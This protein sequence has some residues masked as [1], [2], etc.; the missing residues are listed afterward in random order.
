VCTRVSTDTCILGHGGIGHNRQRVVLSRTNYYLEYRSIIESGSDNFHVDIP[1]V[2]EAIAWCTSGYLVARFHRHV[3][4]T[5][6]GERLAFPLGKDEDMIAI[7]VIVI[8]SR[9]IGNRF[10]LAEDKTRSL[11]SHA[12]FQATNPINALSSHAAQPGSSATVTAAG[13]PTWRDFTQAVESSMFST[14]VPKRAA[15]THLLR[16]EVLYDRSASGQFTGGHR[17][18]NK[19]LCN[20]K[21]PG[22]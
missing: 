10:M 18:V 15:S 12:F 14:C 22:K 4:R 13:C 9:S 1:N 17:H 6:R 7:L 11:C 3:L 16:Q 8:T 19:S 20:S 2:M 21:C 5:D